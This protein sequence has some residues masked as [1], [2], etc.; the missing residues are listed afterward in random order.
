MFTQL[1]E[2]DYIDLFLSSDAMIHDSGSFLA[3]YLYAEKPVMYL[4]RENNNHFNKFG[5]DI[6]KS[7]DIGKSFED[8]RAF[9][10]NLLL[11]K[12]SNIKSTQID[13]FN[14]NIA[15]YFKDKLP[16]DKI[17]EDIKNSI[18]GKV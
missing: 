13:F 14:S 17:I 11:N 9:V 10:D 18:K 3:E 5:Q 4:K 15:I 7:I 16:S 12:K 8:I 6:L 2:G 1:D